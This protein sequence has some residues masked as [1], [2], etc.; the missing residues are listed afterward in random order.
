MSKAAQ[1]PRKN[2]SSSDLFSLAS[3][4]FQES[5]VPLLLV[6]EKPVSCTLP[7]LPLV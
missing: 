2:D 3:I 5:L 7:A 6:G 4:I 1:Y